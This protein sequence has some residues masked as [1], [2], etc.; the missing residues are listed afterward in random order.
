MATGEVLV[1]LPPREPEE[2]LY[3][4]AAAEVAGVQGGTES[5]S[6]VPVCVQ[7]Q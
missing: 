7:S 6:G 1:T 2:R 5:M 4:V 3:R